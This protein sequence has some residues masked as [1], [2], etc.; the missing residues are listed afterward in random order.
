MGSF[1]NIDRSVYV[2]RALLYKEYLK[3][4]TGIHIENKRGK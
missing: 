1:S 3:E 4:L 2:V